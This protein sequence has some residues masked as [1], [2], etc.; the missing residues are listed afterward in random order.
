MYP[1]YPLPL[2]PFLRSFRHDDQT[3]FNTHHKRCRP[4]PAPPVANLFQDKHRLAAPAALP[5]PLL[6]RQRQQQQPPTVARPAPPP[7]TANPRQLSRG[8]PSAIRGAT[9]THPPPAAEDPDPESSRR[10]SP[11]KRESCSG[12]RA[13]QINQTKQNKTPWRRFIFV[14]VA[15]VA[16]EQAGTP[17]PRRL[18]SAAAAVR[19]VLSRRVLG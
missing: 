9:A 12:T 19:R 2:S 18:C 4:F 16:G 10:S 15:F 11:G 3:S 6:R 14:F 8:R 7:V 1:V 13:G 17:G 5:T